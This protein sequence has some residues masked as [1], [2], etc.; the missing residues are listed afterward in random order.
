MSSEK[1]KNLGGA[2]GRSLGGALGVGVVAV[3]IVVRA[4]DIVGGE[5]EALRTAG[6]PA[7][8]SRRHGI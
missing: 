8:G 5:V 6:G 2:A 4:E 7:G 1:G 3:E